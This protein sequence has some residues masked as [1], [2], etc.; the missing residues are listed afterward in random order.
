M[1]ASERIKAPE[2]DHPDDLVAEGSA[3]IDYRWA[4]ALDPMFAG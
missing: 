1:R 3:L 2:G 4:G